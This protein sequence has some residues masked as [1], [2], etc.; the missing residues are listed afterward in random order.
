MNFN[1]FSE[2]NSNFYDKVNKSFLKFK[3]TQEGDLEYIIIKYNFCPRPLNKLKVT[4]V[5]IEVENSISLG[6]AL[7]KA[8]NGFNKLDE[9][10]RISEKTHLYQLHYS[11][12]SGLPDSDI[13]RK[14]I[15]NFIK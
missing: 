6:D 11:K 7:L 8:I 14:K 5:N 2:D 10:F 15:L 13:P 3:I 4:T 9:N 1:E 12:K